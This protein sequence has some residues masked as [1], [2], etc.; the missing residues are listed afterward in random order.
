MAP[1]VAKVVGVDERSGSCRCKGLLQSG[2]AGREGIEPEVRHGGALIGLDDGGL[3]SFGGTDKNSRPLASAW[4]W[5]H[6]S[7]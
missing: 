7:P 3:V 2:L 4:R 5:A 1:V 6:R